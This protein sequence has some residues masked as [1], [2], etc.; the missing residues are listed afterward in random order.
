MDPQS[1]SA[2]PAEDKL[3][4]PAPETVPTDVK[5]DTV[6]TSP[7]EGASPPSMLD[8]VKAALG[9]EAPAKEEPP[10]SAE[11]ESPATAAEPEDVGEQDDDGKISDDER[12]ALAPKTQRRIQKL[13]TQVNELRPL[14]DKHRQLETF[15]RTNGLA[16]EDAIGALDIAALIRLDPEKAYERVNEVA[17]QLAKRLGKVLPADIHDRVQKG[18][19]SE[20]SGREL[21]QTRARL[22]EVEAVQTRTAEELRAEQT[23]QLRQGVAQAVTTWEKTVVAR[24]PDFARKKPLVEAQFRSLVQPGAIASADDAVALMKKAYAAVNEAVKGF[25]PTQRAEV[26]PTPATVSTAAKPRPATVEDAIRQALG[27]VAA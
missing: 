4:A 26:R 27:R 21:A 23:A 25:V 2:P 20:A 8:A 13:A 9:K 3:P 22:A 18:E 24:D 12:K 7:T 6:D 11:T 15:M 14:A 16:A 19:V 1:T 10:A 17:I 5:I